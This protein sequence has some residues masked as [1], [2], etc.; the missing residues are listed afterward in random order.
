MDLARPAQP[1]IP[2]DLGDRPP[3]IEPPGEVLHHRRHDRDQ[4]FVVEPEHFDLD[5][6]AV[7]LEPAAVLDL[8]LAASELHG[9]AVKHEAHVFHIDQAVVG[10]EPPLDVIHPER[11][12]PAG[13][14]PPRLAG[15]A[16]LELDGRL[17]SG[18]DHQVIPVGLVGAHVDLRLHVA[19]SDRIEG[20][21]RLPP[22]RRQ[23]IPQL[24]VERELLGPHVQINSDPIVE[25]GAGRLLDSRL[26]GGQF[27]DDPA[28]G[29][30]RLPVAPFHITEDPL[31]GVELELAGQVR[32]GI[33][34]AV[35]LDRAVFVEAE[36]R[37]D[38]HLALGRIVR[39]G[40]AG[41][42]DDRPCLGPSRSDG[43]RRPLC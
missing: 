35:P 23:R 8:D 9:R 41:P 5:L 33:R 32:H 3:L 21:P 27:L 26:A 37:V 25:A 24:F 15:R 34:Q 36:E 11:E 38:R 28:A 6:L 20:L 13:V 17:G 12:H 18:I 7:E 19:R 1:E 43:T 14:L 39:A 42:L 2:A 16:E 29:D 31:V 30:L 22:G 4:L 10:D 40:P